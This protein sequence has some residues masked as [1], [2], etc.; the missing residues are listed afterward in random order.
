MK[1]KMEKK[2]VNSKML[3][4]C[5]V[6]IS[7]IA[8]SQVSKYILF[9]K[10]NDSIIEIGENNYYKIDGNLFDTKRYSEIDTISNKITVYHT[11]KDLQ[12]EGANISKTYLKNLKE[13]ETI[14]VKESGVETYNSLFN[15]I[16]VL[17]KISKC[18]YKRTR[19]WWIDY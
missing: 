10:S 11:V 14:S 4:F 16:Y 13:D 17:E 6:I 12:T 1:N 7:N 15:Y 5:M 19:V 8:L 18:K 3:F 9:D 2:N